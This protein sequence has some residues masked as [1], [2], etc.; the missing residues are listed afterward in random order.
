[1]DKEPKDFIIVGGGIAGLYCL[2]KL[3]LLIPGCRCMLIEMEDRVGGRLYPIMWHGTRINLGASAIRDRDIHILNLIKELNLEGELKEFTSISFP[4]EFKPLSDK[5]LELIVKMYED[6]KEEILNNNLTFL[7]FL[8]Q[9]FDPNFVKDFIARGIYTDYFNASVPKTIDWY[10]LEDFTFNKKN[11]TTSLK[12]GWDQL[13]KA[14]LDKIYSLNKSNKEDDLIILNSKVLKIIE[15]GDI[16]EVYLDDGRVFKSLDIILAITINNLKDLDIEIHSDDDDNK[17]EQNNKDKN[18]GIEAGED[19]KNYYLDRVEPIPFTRFYT[20]HKDGIVKE[21]NKI[22]SMMITSNPLQRMA[23]ISDNIMLSVYADS[24][25]AEYWHKMYEE[26]NDDKLINQV[27]GMWE[28]YL[29]ITP[30][31]SS[32]FKDKDTFPSIQDFIYK[33]WDVGTHCFKPS[34]DDKDLDISLLSSTP[35][36]IIIHPSN[37]IWIGGEMVGKNQGWSEAAIESIDRLI[38]QLLSGG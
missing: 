29:K 37:K 9:Y 14:L 32:S 15:D 6:N 12:G 33:W 3:L 36:N 16:V 22:P 28:N 35:N 10:P 4:K 21:G 19:I 17:E 34:I 23:Q 26:G 11:T 13:L 2:Y 18:K 1:M 5:E 38:S 30:S 31:I 24:A 27:E 20:Y 8:Y 7:Q 25:M